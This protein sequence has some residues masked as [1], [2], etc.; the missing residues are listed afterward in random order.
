M[1]R[2]RASMT[3]SFPPHLAMITFG[4]P[5]PREPGG[6]AGAGAGAAEAALMA[7]RL[8]RQ[9]PRSRAPPGSG[10]RSTGGSGPAGRRG[11]GGVGGAG[12][13]G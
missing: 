1:P 8:L 5:R 9:R 13:A 12:T 6:R 4:A 3:S 10:A 2:C 7:P 11:S